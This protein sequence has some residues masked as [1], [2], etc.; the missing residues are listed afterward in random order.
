MSRNAVRLLPVCSAMR[1]TLSSVVLFFSVLSFAPRLN[2]S[3]AQT[4][5]TLTVSSSTVNSGE[6]VTLLATVQDSG[7]SP[8]S[9]GRVLFCDESL[10]TTSCYGGAQLA[11]VWLVRTTAKGFAVGSAT[12]K[13]RFSIGTHKIRARY[14]QNANYAASASDVEEVTVSANN[15]LPSTTT[16]AAGTAD[17]SGAYPLTATVTSQTLPAPSDTVTFYDTTD[18]SALG[19]ANLGSSTL[20]L[21]LISTT[22]VA[23]YNIS[24]IAVGD[25]NNDGYLDAILGYNS[26]S[27]ATV[28]L[29]DAHGNLTP[30][31][32]VAINIPYNVHL[33]DLNGDG[34]LD[35][36]AATYGDEH[37]MVALGNGDGTFGTPFSIT[38]TAFTKYPTVIDV[39]DLNGDGLPDLVMSQSLRP[40]LYFFL[41]DGN[42]SNLTFTEAST[43]P[44]SDGYVKR[45]AVGD[46]NEDGYDD[47]A[48]G[49]EYTNKFLTLALA[50]STKSYLSTTLNANGSVPGGTE[51]AVV[52]DLNNDGHLDIVF[53]GK[54]DNQSVVLLG[55]GDGTFTQHQIITEIADPEY[56]ATLADFDGDGNLDLMVNNYAGVTLYYYKG[57]GTGT[58]TLVESH[59]EDASHYTVFGVAQGTAIT[60]GDFNGDGYPDMLLGD[61]NLK[62][63]HISLQTSQTATANITV[64]D[65]S[66]SNTHAVKA[67]YSGSNSYA[68]SN[69]GTVSLTP[70]VA[71]KQT[72]SVTL[73]SPLK[74]EV[75]YGT[76]S[77]GTVNASGSCSG[78]ITLSVTGPATLSSTSS[79]G[80]L[81]ITGSG[82]ISIKATAAATS[83]CA[84]GVAYQTIQVDQATPT[85]SV[86]PTASSIT[87]GQTLASSILTGGTSSVAGSFTWTTSSTAPTAGT[88]SYSVTF[89]P[90]DTTDYGTVTGS[91][92]VTTG[93]A[94]PAISAWPTASSITYG[95]SLASSSLSGGTSSVAGSFT[96]TTSSTA[97]TAGTTSYSVTFTPTDTTDY[98]AVTG[99]ASVT[100]GKATP[101]IS[102]WPTASSITYG[103]TLASSILTG[104]TSSVAGS[105][106]WTT[107]ST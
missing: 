6:V 96:W 93:K 9:A 89:T 61:N 70:V 29:G 77:S 88:T 63:S 7:G 73:D 8:L 101:A 18:V 2:A 67:Q 33:A 5:T 100:T 11:E 65:T 46:F 64:Y 54:A 80:T 72:V 40:H 86:W 48:Y 31:G 59:G 95:Q 106:T 75:T 84:S 107:S 58:L 12:L 24:S 74:S 45:L 62:F 4:T 83:A 97:P 10:S 20:A 14:V 16:I 25:I 51:N 28:M 21:G 42:T 52:G 104:G 82:T 57:D 1:C 37:I 79:G 81:T 36:F 94:T 27:T 22:G 35:I 15:W 98:G 44:T 49:S 41:N 103:Q 76:V 53:M 99:S 56:P 38:A 3:A 87:Y 69:S 43:E 23:S 30:A 32:S 13:R 68:A 47:V 105:F 39:A 55:K 85:V 71:S 92:S 102:A 26:S 50:N 34:V 66:A 78:A 91:A 90:T 60:A 17:A 19:D